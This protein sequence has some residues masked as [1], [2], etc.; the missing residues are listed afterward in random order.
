MRFGIVGGGIGGLT[1]ALVI[2]RRGHEVSV[3]E[4]S[5]A[6][7]E[8]GAGVQISP[9]AGR[10]LHSLGLGD[11]FDEISVHPERMVFRRWEDDSIIRANDFDQ[12]FADQY[13]M[14]LAS[15]ARTD[16]IEILAQ[17]VAAVPNINVSLA[18]RVTHV[19]PGDET[20]TIFFADETSLPFDVVIGADGIHS[21]V[22]PS[23]GGVDS[24]RFSGSVAYRALV[25]LDAVED[26]PVDFTNRVG[27]DRHVVSY[28]IGKDR[29]YLNLVCISPEDTWSTESWTEPGTLDD[30]RER[31]EGWSPEL[32]SILDRVEEPVFRWALYDR[33]P[34]EQWGI[35][36]TTLLGD[37]CHPMLPFMAQGSCQAIEDAAILGRCL[38]DV[39]GVDGVDDVAGVVAALRRYETARQGRTAQVQTTSFM[40]R[41]LFHMPDGEMQQGRDEFLASG[42]AGFGPLEWVYSYDALTA[43]I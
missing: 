17:A 32:L 39:D 21:V 41:D 11:A 20:S 4:R 9:N 10:V 31:F 43:A 18:S 37:A 5:S 25:P 1:A 36:S 6:F 24:A 33:E 16:L 19:E 35:G 13:G 26:L 7:R 8:V 42:V 27:P 30:L 14:A 34:L 40:N 38:D 28:F 12:A 22:R 29:Q 15:V 2:A 23:V 3:F